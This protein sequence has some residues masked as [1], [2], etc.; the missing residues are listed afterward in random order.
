MRPSFTLSVVWW[1]RGPLGERA[2]KG[3]FGVDG[4]VQWRNVQKQAWPKHRVHICTGPHC[5]IQ[6]C[7]EKFA[8]TSVAQKPGPTM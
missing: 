5:N 3:L 8:E 7:L 1:R 6:T 2:R 4:N